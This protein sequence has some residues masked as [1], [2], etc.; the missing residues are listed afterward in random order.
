MTSPTPNQHKQPK[1]KPRNPIGDG[2]GWD[3]EEEQPAWEKRLYEVTRWLTQD[4]QGYKKLQDFI[5]SERQLHLNEVRERVKEKTFGKM[6]TLCGGWHDMD[7]FELDSCRE[8][9]AVKQYKDWL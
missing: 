8:C 7:N 1:L 9:Q 4:E 2:S 5:A 6:K 3:K